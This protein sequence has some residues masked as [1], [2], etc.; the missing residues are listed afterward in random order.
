MGMGYGPGE[1]QQELWVATSRVASAPQHIFYDKLNRLLDEAGYDFVEELS[2]PFYKQ[3][4][5]RSIPPGRY[6]RMLLI[7]YF[8]GID[9][10]RGIAWRCSDSL[11][12]RQF[13]FLAADEDVP[14]HSSL[15]RVRQRLP[16]E[17]HEKV[18]EFVLEVA[19]KKRLLKDGSLCVGVDAT[20]LEANAAMKTIV[21][22][23]TNE[24]WPEYVRRLMVEEGVI[25][26]DDDPTDE[27]L[28]RFDKD[29][30]K[31]GKK[32]VS[33][34]EWVSSTAPDSRILKMKDGRT[35]L[36]YK[37]EHTVDL[38][39]ELIL[40]ADVHHGTDSDT[41]TI[42]ESIATAQRHVAATGSEA[43][44]NE[45]AADKGYHSNT[46]LVD[47]QE[48]GVR[49]YIP[50]RDTGQRKWHDKA[51]EVER[52]FQ[53]NRRRVKRSKGRWLQRLRSELVERTFAHVCETGG[54]RRTWLRGLENVRKRYTIQAAARNLGLMMRWLFGIGTP[55]SL[56]GAAAVLC[57]LIWGLWGLLRR[58]ETLRAAFGGQTANNAPFTATYSTATVEF[59]AV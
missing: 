41:A 45:V 19:R 4:G 23:D 40:S 32:K 24:S 1:R 22:R 29:R 46:A 43:A 27:E 51:L 16:L 7:G 31:R 21:R 5:R 57:A 12:L 44:I 39:S 33:N 28:R 26:E 35:H 20:T 6:F 8:E 30:S 54:A 37:A 13:L 59:A 15:T 10:Q 18:F 56:Q 42:I 48:A 9:S 53:N 38:D 34:E 2:K 14:D 3:A 47:C 36:A 58:L 11:S 50:E 25:D 52:A 55:R 17:V 49:T